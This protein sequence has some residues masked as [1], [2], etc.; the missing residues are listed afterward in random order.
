MGLATALGSD[1]PLFVVEPGRPLLSSLK[2]WLRQKLQKLAFVLFE[3]LTNLTKRLLWELERAN[4][5]DRD[6]VV[7]NPLTACGR[8]FFSQN[9]EDGILLE[10]LRRL[11]ISE[12]SVF[13]EFGVDDGTECNTIILL[14]FG[15]R[16]V[17]VSGGTLS[18]HLPNEKVRLKF[19]R[20]WIT[21]ENAASSALEG[22]A[23]VNADFRD[24]RV[25][26]VDL[27]GNDGPIVR[28]LLAAGVAPDVFIVE[29]NAKF[30][31]GAEFEMPYDDEHVWQK[32]D[33]QGVSLQSWMGIFA[34]KY[35]L[36][37]CNENGTNAFFVKSDHMQRFDDVPKNIDQIYRIGHYGPYTTSGHRT[38][39]RTV[40]YLATR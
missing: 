34:S 39:P 6:V 11:E 33:Y 21:R 24:V 35:T 20:R 37:A 8:R 25:A 13:L 32:D 7:A 2:R 29:Y 4:L 15:W 3:P 9:D 27:D 17:W 19:V 26:S 12:P 38:S 14:A 16:G 5:S 1:Q 36:V 30:P 18:F 22:L 31:P 28:A 10:I 23:A 40:R